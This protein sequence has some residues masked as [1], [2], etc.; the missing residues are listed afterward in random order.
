MI[1]MCRVFCAMMT[2]MYKIITIKQRLPNRESSCHISSMHLMGGVVI[3]FVIQIL[4]IKIMCYPLISLILLDK[5]TNQ[6][7]RAL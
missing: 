7:S 4:A 2:H 3:P 1:A 5:Y 6:A